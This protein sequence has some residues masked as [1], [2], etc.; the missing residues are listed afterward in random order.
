MFKW[1]ILL[2]ATTLS[3]NVFAGVNKLSKEE[4]L[5]IKNG[6]NALAKFQDKLDSDTWQ[7]S[8]PEMAKLRHISLHVT[9]LSG[10]LAEICE[11][12]EHEIAKDP[13]AINN[14]ANLQAEVLQNIIADLMMH[15]AQLSN[16]IE[17]SPYNALSQRVTRNIQRYAPDSQIKLE[18]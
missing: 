7:I 5:Q 6:L 12:W 18:P 17:T 10:S 14:Q 2:V 8:K 9:K 13:N 15:A 16:L 1:T 4:S 3:C 11:K